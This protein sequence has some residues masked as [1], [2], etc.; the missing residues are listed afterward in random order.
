MEVELQ[1]LMPEGLG[2]DSE[3]NSVVWGLLQEVQ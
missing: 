1:G 2:A 3:F